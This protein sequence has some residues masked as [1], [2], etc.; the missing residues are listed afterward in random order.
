MTKPHRRRLSA[1]VGVLFALVLGGASA[2]TFPTRPI[3]LIVPFAP[4]GTTD[5]IGRLVSEKLPAELGQPVVIENK[6]GAGGAIGAA[7]VARAPA[8]GYVLGMAT[9]STVAAN[10]AINPSVPYNPLTDFTPIT[11][12]AATPNVIA[13][14]PS[15][16]AKDYATFIALVRRNPG[17]YGHASAG[18]GGQGH[19]MMEMFKDAAQVQI[20][21]VPYR[22]SGPALMDTVAGQV[23]MIYDNLPS[24]LPF[25][26]EG[27]LVP[28]VVAAPRRLPVLPNVPTFE[29]VGLKEVN[30]LAF[31]GVVGPKGLPPEVTARL[32]GALS[33]VMATAEFRRRVDE[34]GSLLIAN[35]PAEFAAQIEA[36][37][38]A[39]R[40]VVVERGLKPE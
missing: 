21:H 4:G 14:H 20:I 17:K 28:I 6:G 3:R 16:P 39:L 25:L 15:F 31:Y 18:V 12:V 29:E 27:R 38:R 23:T 35:S 34:T 40:K 19:L 7:E 11:N 1:A 37:Y 22:G 8:D 24:A 10:P 13:V 26:K 30:R 9:V 32:Y 5:I 33:R 2:Q 36:E